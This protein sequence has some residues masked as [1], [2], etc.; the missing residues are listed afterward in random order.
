MWEQNAYHQSSRYFMRASTIY[1]RLA[2]SYPKQYYIPL[3][4]FLIS[5][6]GFLTT[7]YET[8]KGEML[9]KE[10]IGLCR[11]MRTM[12]PAFADLWM[13]N[14]ETTLGRLYNMAN[15]FEESKQVL[16]EALNIYQKYYQLDSLFCLKN[17]STSLMNLGTAYFKTFQ[18]ESGDSCYL[19]ATRIARQLVNRSKE[20][21][22]PHLAF[23]LFSYAS[24]RHSL[25]FDSISENLY[26]E[27]L[28][29][30]KILAHDNPYAYLDD[31]A[32]IKSNLAI[33]YA[34][35]QRQHESEL[36]L[37]EAIADYRII[38]QK[39]PIFESMAAMTMAKL[40]SF[41]FM[42]NRYLE[43]ENTFNEAL[44]LWKGLSEND[45]QTYKPKVA[46]IAINFAVYCYRMRRFQKSEA[47]NLLGIKILQQLAI[48]DTQAYESRY[49]GAIDQ[50]ASLYWATQRHEEAERFYKQA[51]DI[52]LR[53]VKAAPQI[54]EK[55][56][57][58][59]FNNLSNFYITNQ[60]INDGETIFNQALDIYRLLSQ[61]SRKRY[62]QEI[63]K[64]EYYL[65]EIKYLQSRYNE[66]ISFLE[67]A[68]S[69]YQC[70][71]KD[72]PH[73]YDL[74][75]A[76]ATGHLAT[77]YI[78]TKRYSKAE[79]MCVK[80]IEIYRRLAIDKPLE[81][82]SILSQTLGSLSFTSLFL[83]NY[84]QAEQYALESLAV[85]STQHW[86]ATNLAHALLFQG[87][88]EEAEELYRQYKDEL[89]DA[90]LDDFRLF[91]EAGAIP[92]KCEAEVE[93]IKKML[94][95]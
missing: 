26:R 17:I 11:D 30:Y 15:R 78:D 2:K 89:K 92:K 54:Y 62:F 57:T 79:E 28:Y 18:D 52:R 44:D 24:S 69:L 29:L 16:T 68:H 19:E 7:I 70:L 25:Q 37:Q 13:A 32:G 82:N 27:A 56:F 47:I 40:A 12:N 20:L 86:I 72:S 76:M 14:A 43:C 75:I 74:Y 22:T 39:D 41:Y 42:S 4:R 3:I 88:T 33:L 80:A 51:F 93:R 34:N 53:L 58:Y 60:R 1:R 81:Y 48:H 91:A 35:S 55:D 64:I 49:A 36:L 9:F 84:K 63:A 8:G 73:I 38:A 85:D 21:H 10:A 46:E 71:S 95:E 6:A 59:T 66:A 67:D 23:V 31:V 61:D 83:K 45:P 87:R 77:I 50:L 90:F 5:Y 94:E 65:G